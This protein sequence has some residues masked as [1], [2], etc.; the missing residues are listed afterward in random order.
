MSKLIED[1]AGTL[2]PPF[3]SM[4]FSVCHDVLRHSA[5]RVCLSRVERLSGVTIDA[6]EIDISP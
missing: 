5:A 3:L 2:S 1:R 4:Y 6:T